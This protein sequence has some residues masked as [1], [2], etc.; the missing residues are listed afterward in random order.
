MLRNQS[1]LAVTNGNKK[2]GN[3]EINELEETLLDKNATGGCVNFNLATVH[4][5][6]II[7][8]SKFLK[9]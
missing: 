8:S 6:S 5:S 4:Y 1:V 7:I 2:Y 3:K 9:L